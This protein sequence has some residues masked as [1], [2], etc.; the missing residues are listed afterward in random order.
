MVR[1]GAPAVVGPKV[2][3]AQ[4]LA[5]L[6]LALALLAAPKII[7]LPPL[8]IWNAS[9]SVPVGLYRVDQA[10]Y[11]LGDLVLIR[12]PPAIAA[13]ADGRGYLARS[14]YLLK[15]IA[16]VEGDRVCRFGSFVF[17]R[18]RFAAIAQRADALGRA[19]PVWHGCRTLRTGQVFLLANDPASFDSRYFGPLEANSITG[20]AV[21][22][23]SHRPRS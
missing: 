5:G 12:L 11:R 16:A 13:F 17:I 23:W 4:F 7:K 21:L 6:L 20:R 14:A 22:L 15:P 19:L 18:R 10:H 8:L 2:V 3:R 1:P 9:P